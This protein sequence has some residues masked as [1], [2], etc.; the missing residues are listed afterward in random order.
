M[1]MHVTS[2]IKYCNKTAYTVLQ[3][4]LL[5]T[6]DLWNVQI[7]LK[8]QRLHG[9]YFTIFFQFEIQKNACYL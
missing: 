5:Y 4:A 3:Y 7:N 6:I 2:F 1:Q 8:T 9:I